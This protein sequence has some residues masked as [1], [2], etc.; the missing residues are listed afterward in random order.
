MYFDDHNPPH[1]HAQYANYK[2]S[3][4]IKNFTILEGYLPPKA[5]SLVVEWASLHQ[6]ELLKNWNDLKESSS[7]KKIEPLV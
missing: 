6:K 4:C 5:H 3:I 2:A 1:F 7:F